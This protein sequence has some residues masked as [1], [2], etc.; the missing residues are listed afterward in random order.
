MIGGHCT[1]C[2]HCQLQGGSATEIRRAQLSPP[3]PGLSWF[4]SL[5]GVTCRVQMGAQGDL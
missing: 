1:S 3:P 4:V 5:W 2:S